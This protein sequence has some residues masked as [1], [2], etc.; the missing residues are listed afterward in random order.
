MAAAR[1]SKDIS[2]TIVYQ[3]TK[4]RNS[5]SPVIPQRVIDRPPSAELA[6]NQC[7]QDTLPP[8]DIL[9]GI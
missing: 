5:I 9:D 3:L 4:Y 1:C 6:P 8:Y 7:D 2:K